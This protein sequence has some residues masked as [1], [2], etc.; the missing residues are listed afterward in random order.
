MKGVDGYAQLRP[1]YKDV[2]ETPFTQAHDA[3]A[4]QKRIAMI[5]DQVR[6]F[7]DQ[8]YPQ[9]LTQLERLLQPVAAPVPLPTPGSGPDG[10]KT[11]P[12]NT[13]TPPPTARETTIVHRNSVRVVFARPWL[14]TEADVDEYLA[15]LREALI[16]EIEASRRVQI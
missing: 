13:P 7:E 16:K 2:L 10:G 5:R 6:V 1:E 15:S 12:P 9:L 8:K 14:A 4:R 3:L 11:L